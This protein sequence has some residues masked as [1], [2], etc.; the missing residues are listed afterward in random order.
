MRL[1]EMFLSIQGEGLDAGRLCTFVRFTACNLRCTYCDTEYAFYEGRKRSQDDLLAAV[2]ELGAPLVCLTGGEPML[3][4]DIHEFAQRLL[5]EGY[6]VSIETSGSLPLDRLPG[7]VVKI[8]D[9][10]TP[11]ALR[12]EG[13]PEDFANSEAFISEHLNYDNLALLGPTDQVKFVLC[14]RADYEWALDFVSEHSLPERVGA[15]L[16]SPIDPGLPPADLASWLTED[17]PPVRLNLQIHKV[18]WGHEVRGV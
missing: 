16:F 11:G 14:D 15:I 4:K 2:A 13:S 18:I 12:K 3:Q 7:A 8:M 1:N 6:E 10:K 9:I 5:D 17:K